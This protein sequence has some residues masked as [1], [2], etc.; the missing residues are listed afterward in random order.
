MIIRKINRNRELTRK[1]VAA[2]CRVS[3][4]REEQE[5]SYETQIANYQDTI[6]ENKDWELAGIYTDKNSAT[7]V[8]KR[9]GFQQMI[10][11]VED[12]KIDLVLVKS[13]SRFSRNIVDCQKYIR[14]MSACNCFIYFE[15]EKIRTDD[16]ASSFVLSIL[17][18]I[19]QDESHSIS[20]NIKLS[21]QSRFKR[22]EYRLGNHRIL[23][24]DCSESGKLIPN[25]DAWIV[26]EV[27]LRFTVGESYSEIVKA[28]RQMGA[29]TLRGGDL[30]CAETIRYMLSNETYAGDKLL[31]K[32]APRDY[33]TKKPDLNRVYES[34]YLKNDHEPL[35][36]RHTWEQ[37]QAILSRRMQEKKDGIYRNGRAHHFFYGKLFCGLCGAPYVRRT[38]QGKDEAY[39]VWVC[40]ERLKGKSGNGC[41]NSRYREDEL[42]E[43]VKGELK[44]K[45]ELKEESKE[46]VKEELNANKIKCENIENLNLPEWEEVEKESVL[47]IK[48]IL[49]YPGR[50][51]VEE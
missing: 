42:K 38:C 32:T 8:E 11:D 40:K 5:E 35:I 10:A 51:E 13:I 28:L 36:D 22:G 15:K 39:K 30:F 2:Y 49:V 31:Q 12:G 18:A 25:A 37:A 29:K 46:K 9:L 44:A 24:Y 41:K 16:M 43:K 26:R 23:G 21:N 7:G 27:F 3:T 1:R 45:E 17:S 4:L 19:A 6:R 20:E 33:L 48:R 50:I 14:R 47:E 34:F